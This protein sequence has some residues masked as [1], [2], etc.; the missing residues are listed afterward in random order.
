[1]EHIRTIEYDEPVDGQR[2]RVSAELFS[3]E[4]YAGL[5][6]RLRL[7]IPPIAG[8]PSVHETRFY[9]DPCKHAAYPPVLEAESGRSI[10]EKTQIRLR[11][12]T[13]CLADYLRVEKV[14]HTVY[15]YKP[16]P[17]P[18]GPAGP[19]PDEFRLP[20]PGSAKK[21][22]IVARA[23]DPAYGALTPAQFADQLIR[24]K[25]HNVIS[26]PDGF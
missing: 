19:L 13:K 10:I 16:G 4:A 18:P 7:S 6:V 17:P 21:V 14:E 26:F 1:M 5:E 9:S 12:V 8:P 3:H 20:I 15:Q 2:I 22:V 11:Q 25:F 23:Y 24:Q